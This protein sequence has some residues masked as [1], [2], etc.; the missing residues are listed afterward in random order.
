MTWRLR[1]F[2]S[3]F[4]AALSGAAAAGPTEDASLAYS[5]YKRADYSAAMRLFRPFADQGH[6]DAQYNLGLMYNDGRGVRQNYSEAV[7]WYRLAAEQGRAAAQNSLA[8]V[9][10]NGT[11]VPQSNALALVWFNLSA[12]QGYKLALENRG[13][14]AASM[15]PAQLAEAQKLAR[16]WQ[17][18]SEALQQIVRGPGELLAPSARATP[19]EQP[20]AA[21]RAGHSIVTDATQAN[22]R[23]KTG[24]FD[25]NGHYIGPPDQPDPGAYS[26]QLEI[27]SRRI[28]PGV[29]QERQRQLWMAEQEQRAIENEINRSKPLRYP[30]DSR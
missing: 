28:F 13:L 15:T 17:S 21:G 26:P 11:G 20:S 3:L 23:A 2:G 9:Y 30:V 14:V 27:R 24:M 19:E 7:R 12:V 18:R 5:A 6:A 22:Q 10:N 1:I 25:S 29:S 8:L 16:D 4:L